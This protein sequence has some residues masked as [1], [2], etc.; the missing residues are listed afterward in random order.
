MLSYSLCSAATQKPPWG[1]VT[2]TAGQGQ[3]RK[4]QLLTHCPFI[5]SDSIPGHS[6]W[7]R[8]GTQAGKIHSFGRKPFTSSTFLASAYVCCSGG[9]GGRPLPKPLAHSPAP[10]RLC[11][12]S[13]WPRR[14]IFVC[15]LLAV[16]P[17]LSIPV[18]A[19]HRG[20]V[21]WV[22]GP[23]TTDGESAVRDR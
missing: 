3:P 4:S 8:E 23:V 15:L 13:V 17:A 5:F 1:K 10:S 14:G 9:C 12:L 7:L 16:S 22:H 19:A 11:S 6:L 21:C 18:L 20:Q 2:P